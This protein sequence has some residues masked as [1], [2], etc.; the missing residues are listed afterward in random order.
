GLLPSERSRPSVRAVR[1]DLLYFASRRRPGIIMMKTLLAIAL[2]A[3]LVAATPTGATAGPTRMAPTRPSLAQSSSSALFTEEQLDNL[4]APIAL[5]PDPLLAQ[6]LPASTFVDQIDQAARWH[7]ANS[8]NTAAIDQQAWDVSV[9]SVAHYP[10][11]LYK[12]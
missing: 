7:R 6:M 9:R 1:R 12:M 2:A 4:L 8:K 10:Q 11:V 5:Y 3:C